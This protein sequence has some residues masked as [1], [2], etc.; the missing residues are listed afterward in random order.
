MAFLNYAQRS[1]PLTNAVCLD[2][3][4]LVDLNADYRRASAAAAPPL[5]VCSFRPVSVH[6]EFAQSL[7]G[8][9]NSK[10]ECGLSN[11]IWAE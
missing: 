6:A 11:D 10:E 8:L 9:S 4:V 2:I 5:L 7:L 1:L 3:R